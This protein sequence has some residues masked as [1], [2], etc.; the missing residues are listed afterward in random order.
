M[1]KYLILLILLF[2]LLQTATAQEFNLGGLFGKDKLFKLN[3]GL[4]SSFIYN[5]TSD[6]NN[7]RDPFTMV[8]GGNLNFFVAGI[9]VPLSFAYSNAEV[10][11]TPPMNF[12]RFSISPT[13]KWAT[14]HLGTSSTVFSPYSLNGFQYDGVGVDLTPGKFKFKLMTGRLLRGTGDYNQNPGVTP[15]YKRKGMG[16]SAEYEFEGGILVGG[17]LFHAKEDSMSAF[18]IPFELGIKP[19]ENIV[20]SFNTKFVVLKQIRVSGE[21]A[22]NFLT[23]DLT[24]PLN[25]VIGKDVFSG[26]LNVNGSTKRKLAGNVKLD[27]TLG[28][29]DMG[30]EYEKVDLGYQCLG[31]YYNQNGFE[32]SLMR[33]SF[34]L[35][36]NKLTLSPSYGIQRDLADSVSSQKGSRFLTTINANY[37]PTDKLSFNGTFS[38]NQSITDFRNLDNIS[39]SNNLIPYYLDS[40]RLVQLNMN[41]SVNANYIIKSDKEIKQSVSGS[42]SLQ[43]GTKKGGEF[44][45]DEEANKFHNAIISLNTLFPNTTFQYNVNFNYNLST[46]G[47]TSKTTAFGPSF[48]V[49]K[50]FMKKKLLIQ[51]GSSYNTT[52]TNDTNLRVNVVNFRANASYNIKDRHDFRFSG[53]YQVKSSYNGLTNV[54]NNNNNGIITLTYNYNF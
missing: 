2:Q 47:L 35:F 31:S 20:A 11:V 15:F 8:L 24:S 53:I 43:K 39:N 29:V 37:N 16:F 54:N 25:P 38:N 14:L 46:Q 21:I 42:Y 1:K 44:F 19:K 6:P 52:Y 10:S 12:N 7:Q 27:Y 4:N 49:G 23:E 22:K 26:L 48:T 9:N 50:K 30:L 40:I 33:V 17:S 51:I 45:I 3:G 13:Y 28:S 36:K 41:L 34:P 18:N 5:H 32:N